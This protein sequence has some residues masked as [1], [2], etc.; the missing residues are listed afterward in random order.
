MPHLDA[1]ALTEDPQGMEFLAAVLDVPA[2]HPVPSWQPDPMAAMAEPIV[3][4][5]PVRRRRKRA[6]LMPEAA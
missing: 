3:V 1:S 4:K 2:G 6:A 5:P